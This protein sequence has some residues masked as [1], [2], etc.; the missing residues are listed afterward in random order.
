MIYSIFNIPIT[1]LAK[2][3]FKT[4]VQV[5]YIQA[6]VDGLQDRFPNIP[7]LEAFDPQKCPS[8]QNE[9]IHYG[10]GKLRLLQEK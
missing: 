6:V 1:A 3:E 9:L 8:S 5:K 2:Q 10:Q 7:E 4:H